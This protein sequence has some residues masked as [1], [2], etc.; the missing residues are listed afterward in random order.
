MHAHRGYY[1]ILCACAAERN[2]STGSRSDQ[3][4]ERCHNADEYVTRGVHARMSYGGVTHRVARIP[5]QCTGRSILEGAPLELC[6]SPS[7]ALDSS[8]AFFWRIVCIAIP[9]TQGG[10]RLPVER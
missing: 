9:L 2:A 4:S 3:L 7:R 1:L 10:R 6:H 8:G 5:Q